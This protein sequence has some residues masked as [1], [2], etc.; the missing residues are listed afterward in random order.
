MKPVV[1]L[2]LELARELLRGPGGASAAL[3]A[4]E[5]RTREDIDV[6]NSA[7]VW[8]CIAQLQLK[9]GL[10]D[11]A[12]HSSE[13]AALLRTAP[14]RRL[15]FDVD[16]RFSSRE[17]SKGDYIT[18][19]NYWVFD[20]KQSSPNNPNAL[21]TDVRRGQSETATQLADIAE[22]SARCREILTLV[23]AETEHALQGTALQKDL[24][25]SQINHL[26]WMRVLTLKLVLND[27]N[28]GGQ[29]SAR[30]KAN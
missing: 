3:S 10:S 9:L 14:V 21:V 20:S 7:S 12:C 18:T 6:H 29:S 17:Q 8:A 13:R 22:S 16:D 1:V 26:R 30:S 27:T 23:G 24:R 2:T 28:K 11:A 25:R 15:T 4:L 19:K 5:K